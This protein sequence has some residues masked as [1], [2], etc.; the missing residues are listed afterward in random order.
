VKINVDRIMFALDVWQ[1]YDEAAT[2]LQR[3]YDDLGV[4]SWP[5]S[6]GD[7]PEDLSPVTPE[8][9]QQGDEIAALEHQLEQQRRHDWAAYSTALKTYIEAQGAQIE[10]LRVPVLVT[11]DSEAVPANA[12]SGMWGSGLGEPLA[13]RRLNAAIDATPPPGKKACSRTPD[14]SC[15]L[16]GAAFPASAL[17]EISASTHRAPADRAPDALVRHLLRSQ[18]LGNDRGRPYAER[19]LSRCGSSR[20]PTA[21][22][23]VLW[24]RCRRRR[25]IYLWSAS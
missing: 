18:L 3:R 21:L 25:A 14:R 10:G 13:D 5:G 8:Q 7:A 2:A 11:I 17:L 16:H 20:R 12:A 23:R 22:A 9:E 1:A 6:S 19:L 24:R 4:A 15:W